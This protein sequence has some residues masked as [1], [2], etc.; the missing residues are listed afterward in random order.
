LLQLVNVGHKSLADYATI[1]TRGLMDEIRRLAAPLAG[2]RVVHLSATAFG[3]GVAEI[4]YTLIPL[5][6]DAGLEVEWRIIRGA[7]EFYNVTKTIH[8]A[9]QGNPQG[10]DDEQKEIYGRYQG[11]NADRLVSRVVDRIL[12]RK[13]DR[14]VA[15]PSPPAEAAAPSPAPNGD[16]GAAPA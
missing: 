16:A 9:L 8:N 1:A 6:Q 15:M 3:G 10:L 11:M 5:M 2:R 7:E 4:N 12:F 13:G 14:D